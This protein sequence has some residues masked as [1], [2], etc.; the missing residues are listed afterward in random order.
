MSVSF[1]EVGAWHEAVNERRT[2]VQTFGPDATALVVGATGGIGAAFVRALRASGRFA[3][4]HEASRS[5]TRVV[6]YDR[7]DTI[8]SAVEGLADLDLVLVAT[9]ML[10]EGDLKPEKSM[11][12]LDAD[13]LLRSYRINA[14]G[15]ALVAKHALPLMRRDRKTAFAALSARVGSIEDN[16]LG[17]WH[18]YRAAKAGLNMLLR[19]LAIE[20][21]R[22]WPESMVVG[23]HP[24]TVDTGLS[25][26]FQRNV[27]DLFTP[28]RSAAAMLGVLDGLGPDATGNVYDWKGE[29][30]PG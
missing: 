15:P 17:G 10:H 6:D 26:P 24:G 16:R 11:R 25:E 9:G 21:A 29:R 13:A 7:P 3:A 5:G 18:G 12:A 28:E 20:H 14:V 30:I 19:N 1:V 2:A 22:R 23:L 4:V 27:G 8:A